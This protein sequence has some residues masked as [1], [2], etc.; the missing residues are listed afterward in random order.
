M[1][2]LG[3]VPPAK[4]GDK[5]RP[6]LRNREPAAS[7]LLP[8]PTWW[9]VS[10][11]ARNWYLIKPFVTTAASAFSGSV[12]V[13]GSQSFD[14]LRSAMRLNFG[15]AAESRSRIWLPTKRRLCRK[16]RP[17]RHRHDGDPGETGPNTGSPG[18][19]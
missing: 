12:C 15:T 10:F 5:R 2:S 8:N 11:L 4:I 6:I 7:L 14:I 16:Y 1:S 13:T 3:T 17:R 9:S 19:H 18:D